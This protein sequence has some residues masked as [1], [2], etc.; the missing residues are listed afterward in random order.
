[1]EAPLSDELLLRRIAQ[2]DPDALSALYDRHARTVY[3]LSLRIVRDTATADEVLQDTFWQVWQSAEQYQHEGA[4]TAWLFRIA[5]NKGLDQLRR[6]KTRPQPISDDGAF[7]EK[8]EPYIEP[9]RVEQITAH[10]LMRQHVQQA[11]ADL[12]NEQRVCLELAYFEGLSQN[13]IAELTRTPVGTV[14]TRVRMALEK[15][16]R[17][18]RAVGYMPGDMET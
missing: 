7:L 18:L 16:E 14:K 1:M 3:N 17:M 6:Q 11:L 4:V 2:R 9:R 15:M 10:T 8:A 5:R 12:P 13:Q